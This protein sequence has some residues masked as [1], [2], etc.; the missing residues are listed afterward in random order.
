MVNGV[1]LFMVN[2]VC[3]ASASCPLWRC[4]GKGKA[5]EQYHNY[6]LHL[7][8]HIHA[9]GLSQTYLELAWLRM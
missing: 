2:G 9:L 3:L 7:Q 8:E 4:M 1:C 5:C 6:P